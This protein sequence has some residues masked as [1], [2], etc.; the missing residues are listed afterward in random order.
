[1]DRPLDSGP[2]RKGQEAGAGPAQHGCFTELRASC[3][4]QNPRRLSPR[5]FDCKRNPEGCAGSGCGSV[6]PLCRMSMSRCRSSAA[7]RCRTPR[8]VLL[9]VPRRAFRSGKTWL[10]PGGPLRHSSPQR[11]FRTDTALPPGRTMPRD[12]P[13]GRTGRG[14][15]TQVSEAGIDCRDIPGSLLLEGNGG[16]AFPTGKGAM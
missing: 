10:R 4:R 16:A 9:M 2:C 12:S 14:R 3:L 11:L 7:R 13:L 1:V 6:P 5:G 8:A 15:I